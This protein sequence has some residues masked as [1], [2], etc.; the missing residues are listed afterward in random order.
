VWSAIKEPKWIARIVWFIGLISA[1]SALSPAVDSRLAMIDEMVP[2]IF[3]VAATIGALTSGILL[4]LLARALKRGKRRAWTVAVT[5]T[6]LVT[7]FHIVKGA[8]LEEAVLTGA[9]FVILVLA[10]DNFTARADPHSTRRL[11]AT[12]TL[13]PMLA[14]ATGWLLLT[15]RDRYEVPGSTS[16]QR[17]QEAVLGLIGIDGPLEFVSQKHQD[18]VSLGLILLSLGLI[19][20]PVLLVAAQPRGG[21]H[22]LTD[23]ERAKLRSILQR[24][25]K[26]DSLSYFALRD[27]RSVIFNKSEK[28]ALTY[29]VIAN[30]SLAAG[31]PLGDPEAWQGVIEQWLA[32]AKSYGWTPAVLG[33]SEAGAAAF[34]RAGME[35]LELGDEAI[36]RVADFSLDGREMRGIRQA[37]SRCQRSGLSVTCTRLADIPEDT[38][39]ELITKADEWRDG[40]VERGFSMALN[41]FC[42]DRDDQCVVVQTRNQDGELVGLLNFVPWGSEGLSLDLMRRAHDTENG[43]M[44]FMVAELWKVCPELGIKELSL[45]FAVLRYVFARGERLGAGPVLRMWRSVLLW[46]SRFWQIE[47]LYRANAKYRPEWL[48]RFLCFVNV[49]DLPTVSTA[50]LR[51]EAFLV[52]PAWT[53]KLRRHSLSSA[54]TEQRDQ[55]TQLDQASP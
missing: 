10:K 38:R 50:A 13:M 16:W 11:V 14:I 36:V 33:A 31:D 37:V 2:T 32:E 34:H 1:L 54:T 26:I 23:E 20:L 52:A 46:L 30:V 7:V 47:S 18:L 22:P 6:G 53:H 4:I 43:V 40:A 12:A 42:E 48:P 44:E 41:R 45:N 55:P 19:V 27:D 28:A 39:V 29:R 24:W 5:L 3:P 49:G 21:P 25:G 35:A 9:V 15:L 8:D 17:L 51:A